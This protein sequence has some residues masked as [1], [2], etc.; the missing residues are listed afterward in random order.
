MASYGSA[1]ISKLE[2]F[3]ASNM[4]GGLVA[5]RVSYL[6]IPEPFL[7]D[8]FIPN[9]ARKLFYL[10]NPLF[11]EFYDCASL[12]KEVFLATLNSS[13]LAAG[14]VLKRVGLK[15]VLDVLARL[16][17]TSYVRSKLGFVLRVFCL[18]AFF[19]FREAADLGSFYRFT[20]LS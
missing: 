3:R 5:T 17:T 11:L 14:A 8:G 10:C 15:V 18:R 19:V 4:A 12:A 6:S 1:S 2:A 7:P 20:K 16:L 9:A 13:L